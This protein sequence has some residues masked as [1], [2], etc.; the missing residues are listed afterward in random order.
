SSDYPCIQ[1]PLTDETPRT[2]VLLDGEPSYDRW[3]EAIGRGRTAVAVGYDDRLDL[4]VEGAR[5]GDELQAHAGDTLDCTIESRSPV[6]VDV[7]LL[8]N[9]AA[10][11]R[12]ALAPGH[13][14]ASVR[15][16]LAASSW[17]SAR[18]Q[19]VETSPVYVLADSRPIRASA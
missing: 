7:E 15:L 1:D 3:L 17:I 12:V 6:A 13:Q 8:V 4:R 18:T 11:A 9:G 10:A 19:S 5:I 14:A 2:D 16:P